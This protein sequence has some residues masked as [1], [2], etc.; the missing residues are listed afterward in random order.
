MAEHESEIHSRAAHEIALAGGH[1]EKPIGFQN[2]MHPVRQGIFGADKRGEGHEGVFPVGGGAVVEL[3]VPGGV[4]E[5]CHVLHSASAEGDAG[6]R[7]PAAEGKNS[8]DEQAAPAGVFI[9]AVLPVAEVGG[10]AFRAYAQVLAEMDFERTAYAEWQ[11]AYFRC[12]RNTAIRGCECH[13]SC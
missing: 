7:E 10:I 6:E 13:V 1:V 2:E 9:T 12:R 4:P 11:P 8:I 3:E 5:D